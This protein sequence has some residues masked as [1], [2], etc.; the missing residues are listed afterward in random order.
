M[1]A[2]MWFRFFA[3]FWLVTLLHH[4]RIVLGEV[5][6]DPVSYTHLDVYKRQQNLFTI[7]P[8]SG[9]DPDLLD[10]GRGDIGLGVDHGRVPNPFQ[11]M[12]GLSVTF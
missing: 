9:P 1:L 7:T 8:Y 2:R 11:I 12:G 5:S 6:N 3:F 4:S 10:V